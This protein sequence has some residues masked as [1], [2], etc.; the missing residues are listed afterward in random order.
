METIT[1]RRLILRAPKGQDLGDF[2]EYARNPNVGPAAGWKPH[3]DSRESLEILTGFIR[4]GDVWSVVDKLTNKM[5]GTVALLNDGKRKNNG[6]RML[7]YALNEHYWGQGIATE[8]A[9]AAVKY[10]F[11][12]LGLD[13]ITVYHFTFNKRSKSVIAKCGFKFEGVLRA[14]FTSYDG[15][16]YDEACYSLTKE[17]Y[18]RQKENIF[19]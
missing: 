5:I 15:H 11:E 10:G 7:G 4:D 12:N 9:R 14:A 6:V 13:I 18:A 2:Y 19:E 1:T 3:A 16:I 8:A 17:E